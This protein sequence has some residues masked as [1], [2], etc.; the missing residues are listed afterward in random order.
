M[1]DYILNINKDIET[2]HVI[3]TLANSCMPTLIRQKPCSLIGFQ[4]KYIS[5]PEKLNLLLINEIE[6]FG[7]QYKLLYENEK[8]YFALVY[9]TDLLEATLSNARNAFILNCYGYKNITTLQALLDHFK[10]RFSKYHQGELEFPDELGILLGYPI[11][12]VE[13]YIKNKGQNYKLCGYWK[14][15]DNVEKAQETFDYFKWISKEAVELIFS[16]KEL[17][18]MTELFDNNKICML[19]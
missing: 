5:S 13:Q 12:D 8:V 1:V 14:V 2:A 6:Y 3:Y 18:E 9:S 11:E 4:K 17:S 19:L 15:Y 16:G 10:A 7:C